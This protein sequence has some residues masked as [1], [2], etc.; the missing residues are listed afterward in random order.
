MKLINILGKLGGAALKS[1]PGVGAA[2]EI[3]GFVN[4][5]LPKDKQVS[6]NS[7]GDKVLAVIKDLP[8]EQMN[9]VLI[10]KFDVEIEEIKGHSEVIKALADVDKVGASTRPEI[11]KLY[12][13]LTALIA[14]TIT[15]GLTFAVATGNNALLEQVQDL[16]PMVLAVITPF[17]AII[18]SYFGM[19]TKEKQQKYEAASGVSP[20]VGA[21]SKLMDRFIK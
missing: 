1:I 5:V 6:E 18:R 20:I 13:Y 2:A 7:T 14:Y 15:W 19:R 4:G 9:E 11:A 10:K 12:A 17:V 8:T 21:A 3:I 16:W